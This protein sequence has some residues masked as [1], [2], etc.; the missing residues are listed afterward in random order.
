VDWCDARAYCAGVGKRLCGKIGGGSNATADNAN[1]AKSQWYNACSSGGV[2]AYPYGNTRDGSACNAYDHGTG[3]LP[4]GS[5]STCQSSIMGYEG[6][7]DMSGNVYEW[8]DSCDNTLESGDCLLGGGS[9]VGMTNCDYKIGS[10][11]ATTFDDNGI[12]CCSP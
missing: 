1:A 5:L 2:N 3:E 6:V 7:F 4:V 11:P 8:E 10:P 9:I 12:R